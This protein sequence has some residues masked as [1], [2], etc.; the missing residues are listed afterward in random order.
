LEAKKDIITFSSEN[1]S[2]KLYTTANLTLMKTEQ[3]LD[4]EKINEQSQ[5]TVSASF[6]KDKEELQ[7]AAPLIANANLSYKYSWSTSNSITSTISYN[8]VSD[9]LNL[10]GYASLGNQID[11]E[12]HNLDFVVKSKLKN[13]GLNLSIK[14]ILNQD[15]DR[16]QENENRNWVVKHHKKGVKFSLGLNYTF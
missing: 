4:S 13:F 9:R 12:I 14:N 1:S 11:K 15:V 8:Y 5:Q 16:I 3:V 2:K 10:I 6:N 7:G